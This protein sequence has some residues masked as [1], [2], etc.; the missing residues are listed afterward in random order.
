MAQINYADVL[1]ALRNRYSL[2]DSLDPSRLHLEIDSLRKHFIKQVAKAI[3]ISE[4]QQILLA[5]LQTEDIQKIEL[6]QARNA[7]SS[8]IV[9]Y[10]EMNH[11]AILFERRPDIFFNVGCFNRPWTPPSLSANEVLLE[12]YRKPLLRDLLIP[13]IEIGEFSNT[14]NSVLELSKNY[15]ALIRAC[16]NRVQEFLIDNP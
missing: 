3:P 8:S 14:R 2:I 5:E 11:V 13:M 7:A 1:V 12:E 4:Q 16:V 9:N 10:L 15:L 6:V